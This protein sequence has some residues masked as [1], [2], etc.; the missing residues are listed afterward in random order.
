MPVIWEVLFIYGGTGLGWGA[1]VFP[2]IMLILNTA[3]L[4]ES[5]RTHHK[6]EKSQASFS[7]TLSLPEFLCCR[8]LPT[9][10]AQTALC[11]TH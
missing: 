3:L 6:T 2:S 4:T 8:L 10:A 9:P 7:N 1:E 5:F 11:S